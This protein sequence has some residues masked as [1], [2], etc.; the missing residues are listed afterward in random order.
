[1]CVCTRAHIPTHLL[2]PCPFLT[3]HVGY[4]RHR[5][6]QWGRKPALGIE[7]RKVTDKSHTDL[8]L[9]CEHSCSLRLVFSDVMYSSQANPQRTLHLR[10]LSNRY[11]NVRLANRTAFFSYRWSCAAGTLVCVMQK[12]W[13][14]VHRPVKTIPRPEWASNTVAGLMSVQETL[15]MLPT[16]LTALS[17][18]RKSDVCIGLC[19]ISN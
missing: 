8:P 13:C 15:P 9:S 7:E 1:M 19:Q 10:E 5:S 14:D 2:I 3:Y 11:A 18:W 4:G 6:I 16:R 12:S 17:L